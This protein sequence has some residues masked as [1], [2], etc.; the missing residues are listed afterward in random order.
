[1]EK[2]ETPWGRI[3]LGAIILIAAGAIILGM[4]PLISLFNPQACTV[5]G[6]CQHEQ[7]LNALE[8]SL[9]FFVGLGM[10]IGAGV[11]WLMARQ[12]L[13]KQK[14]LHGAAELVMQFLGK[15]ERAVVK[16]LVDENGKALQSEISRIEGIGKLKSHRILQR[17][18]DKGVIEIEKFGKTNIIRLGKNI[19]EGLL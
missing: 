14:S 4:P 9:P 5:D 1:M 19:K 13:E 17:M 8:Q 10:L 18:K 11:Y 6:V 2:Q 12:V 7:M 15:E 16:K 3:V